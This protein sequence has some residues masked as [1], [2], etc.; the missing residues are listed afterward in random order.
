MGVD[1][2][3]PP[4]GTSQSHS[5]T[6]PEGAAQRFVGSHPC[7]L[8]AVAE[9]VDQSQKVMQNSKQWPDTPKV[10]EAPAERLANKVKSRNL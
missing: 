2:L 1:S 9:A 8:S 6:A 4:A 5:H 10:T 7:S 3:A